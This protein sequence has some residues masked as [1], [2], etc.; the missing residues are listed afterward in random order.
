MIDLKKQ[1]G[2][3]YKIG[4][5]PAAFCESNGKQDPWLYIIPCQHGEIYPHSETKLAFYTDQFR[6]GTPPP[7]LK[8]HLQGNYELV[9]LFSPDDLEKVAKWC[10]AKRRRRVSPETRQRLS[11]TLK[12][13]RKIK[14]EGLK[15]RQ[16]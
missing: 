4:H 7:Q 13:A 5:D 2:K 8:L 12:V 9:Y 3:R 11:D 14:Q 6:K 10:K 1:F 16:G 15:K